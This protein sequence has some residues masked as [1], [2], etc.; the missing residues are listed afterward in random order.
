MLKL[1]TY[2]NPPNCE[3]RVNDSNHYETFSEFMRQKIFTEYFCCDKEWLLE[4][5]STTCQSNP[6]L[7]RV[8]NNIFHIIK[9]F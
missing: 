4:V 7:G 9:N 1:S 3:L 6:A 2:T 5:D 8:M